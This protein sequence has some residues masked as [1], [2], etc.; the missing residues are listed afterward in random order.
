MLRLLAFVAIE[1][2]PR[3]EARD[4]IAVARGAGIAVHM[5]TG[6]H[7]GT[8]SA[9]A[10]KLGIPGDALSGA[11]L[12]QL[13]D[14]ELARRAPSIGVHLFDNRDPAPFRRR[15]LDPG[16]VEYLVDA[17]YDVAAAERIRT[18]NGVSCDDSSRLR[19]RF[20]PT[21]V[22]RVDRHPCGLADVLAP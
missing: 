19:S 2:P 5:I 3:R 17:G 7:V 11:E 16:L 9:I 20:A 15:D 13:D 6:D 4:A 18:G 10:A 14:A 21:L 1:D 8:A 12:D 22:C